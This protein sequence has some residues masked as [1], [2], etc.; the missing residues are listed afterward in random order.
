MQVCI[1][2]YASSYVCTMAPARFLTRLLFLFSAVVAALSLPMPPSQRHHK[3]FKPGFWDT[4][5]ETSPHIQ[6]WAQVIRSAPA[7]A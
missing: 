6:E 1:L 7:R 4:D 5:F 2:Y 3:E